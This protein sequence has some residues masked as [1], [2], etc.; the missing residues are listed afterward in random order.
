MDGKYCSII[1][2]TQISCEL[3]CIENAA[4]APSPFDANTAFASL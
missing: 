2:P 4:E 3:L 1:A